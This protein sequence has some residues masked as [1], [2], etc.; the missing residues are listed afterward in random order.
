MQ[1]RQSPTAGEFSRIDRA[2]VQEHGFCARAAILGEVLGTH[3]RGHLADTAGAQVATQH[4]CYVGSELRVIVDGVCSADD[5][6]RRHGRRIRG[7]CFR[8]ELALN[9]R[10]EMLA[11]IWIERTDRQQHLHLIGNDV[12]HRAAVDGAHGDYRR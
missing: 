6:D 12:R 7:R 8:I 10:E 3:L 1:T 11:Y 4:F 5:L 2:D 9:C